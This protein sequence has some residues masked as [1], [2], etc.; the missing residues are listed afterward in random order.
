MKSKILLVDDEQDIVSFMKDALT[1][2]GYHVYTA[3]DGTEALKKLKVE[4]DLIVLDVMMPGMDGFI[5]CEL[6]RKT[7]SSPIL[8]L[9]AKQSEQDRIKGLMAG[10][11]DY[12]IKPFSMKE[13]KTRIFA[14]LRREQRIGDKKYNR[15]HFGYLT[16][17]LEGYEVLY[18]NQPIA[19]TS[20]EFE[21]FH[22][23]A[24]HPGQ[25]FTR[26]HL[27]EKIWGYDAT[28]DSSTI[29]EHIKKI[30]A[31]LTKIHAPSYISTVWGIGYKW[32]S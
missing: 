6:V 2:E 13:L 32:E 16:I 24:L 31:K 7:V 21:L 18:N 27:Y 1:D 8:F 9:S 12:L 19:F 4:P 23:L 25:V 11:D 17:D 28:G 26:E 10:G 20:K 14:H 15:L 22:F 5:L 29:T 3:Y 30:R